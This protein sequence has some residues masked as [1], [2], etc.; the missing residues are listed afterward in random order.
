MNLADL[1]RQA[2]DVQAKASA[3]QEQLGA[4][5]AE[6]SSGAGMVQVTLNGKSELKKLSIDPALLRSEDREMIE[7]LIVA[8]HSDAKAKIDRRVADEMQKLARDMGLPPGMMGLG[9]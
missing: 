1:F 3:I 4:I 9:A 7:D 8:A 6:G 5:E 2:K